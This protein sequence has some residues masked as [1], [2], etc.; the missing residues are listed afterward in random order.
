MEGKVEMYTVGIVHASVCAPKDM[1]TDEILSQSNIL[2]PV[3]P[4]GYKEMTGCEPHGWAISEDGFR[5]GEPNP[6][7]CNDN[8]ERLHY[9]LVC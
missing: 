7:P 8:P 6:C 1:P 5:T 4:A 2:H 3:C 9:L